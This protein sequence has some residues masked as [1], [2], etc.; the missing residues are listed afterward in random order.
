[1]HAS[2]LAG[3]NGI[4]HIFTG[5]HLP[6]RCVPLG[7]HT[8]PLTPVFTS[9]TI[10][11]VIAVTTTGV[12]KAH[13]MKNLNSVALCHRHYHRCRRHHYHQLANI[14]LGHLLTCYG[15]THLEVSLMVSPGF[16]CLLVC[17]S[18]LPWWSITRHLFVCCKQFLLYSCILSK[19]GVIA[20][21]VYGETGQAK[22]W[23]GYVPKYWI[24]C[25][26]SWNGQEISLFS[27]MSRLVLGST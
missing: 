12:F 24:N 15:L 23:P 7:P 9:T 25:V 14:E 13:A 3:I 26:S 6:A 19:I 10:I 17:S 18:L 11:T 8:A 20:I 22:W 21:S 5:T 1:M 2:D 27:K 4:S 16:F